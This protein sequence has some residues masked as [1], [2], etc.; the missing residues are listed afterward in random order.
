MQ[1]SP[2]DKIGPYE[3]LASI[4]AGGMGEVYRAQDARLNRDVAIKVSSAQFSERFEREAKAI[5]AL[6]HPNICQIY[7]IGPNYL[8]MEFVDGIP[9][10]S[11]ERPKALPP[12][13]ARRLATQIVAALEAAHAKGIIHRDIKPANILATTGGVVKLL[14]FGLAKQSIGTANEDVTQ[15]MGVTQAGTILGTP[16]YMSPEQAEGRTA[17]ARSDIFSFGIVLYEMLSGRRAFAGSSAAAVIGAI[18]HKEPEPLNAP[19]ELE[20]IVRRCL[21]KSPDDR[22]QTATDL[23]RALE[24]ASAQGI[25]GVKRR[26]IAFAIAVSLLVIGAAGL[27]IYLNGTKTSRIDSIA[28]LP[29]ENHDNNPDADYISDGITE[30]VN[31]SLAQVPGLKVIPHSVALHYR[32]NALDIQK[33]GDQLGVRAVLS[34]RVGQRGDNL[35]VGVEL[36][37]V[38]N[39]KQLWGEQYNGKLADLLSVQSDIAREV[40][41]RLRL[42][43]S[44]TD[45]A[46]LTRGSTNNPEAYQLYLKGKYYTNEFTKEGFSKGLDYFHQAVAID[47][48]YGLA[49]NGLAYNYINQQDWYIRPHEAGPKAK[50][51]AERAL[52]IDASDSDAYVALAIESQW[53]EW[54]WPASETA[55][56]RAI[57]L[58]PNNSE[59]HAYYSWLLAPMGRGDQ[60]LAE[61]KRA[62]QAAP[63]SP[64]AN[65]MVGSAFV[66]TR[67]W[68]LAVEQLRS[69]KELDP[70]FWFNPLF[71]GRAYEQQ[72]KFPEAIA[73]FQRA[74]ELDK[75]NTEIWSGIGHAY[76]LSGNRTKAQQVL[77]HLKELSA[78]NYVA[79]YT[80]AVIYA[81]LGDK[82]QAFA[83]LERA[84]KERSY[85]MAVY[86]VTDA[87]LDSLHSDL[88]FVDLRRRVGLPE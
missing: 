10:V 23:R 19:P 42:Q 1:L 77:D 62:V 67:Q 41:Q 35:T 32:G 31:N 43:L 50:E 36:D 68:D 9:I 20:A 6:N 87:R 78:H 49:Y 27:G 29:L 64:L 26:P 18:V 86:L 53:Y 65:F 60:A 72:G 40:S 63:F 75:D 83:W 76:A 82:H 22:F 16:S 38:G 14:D 13:E 59:A 33:I 5:A 58:N 30:S 84:Y 25:S 66:F 47:P 37:D 80:Y 12:A 54:N 24:G 88:R 85:F 48:N 52:A 28:V 81:G 57:E 3:I 8:V 55:F 17:D 39:G 44:V 79:P 61:A 21:S 71:L 74:L 46:Q 15:S 45:Q 34:G 73:E 56:K 11:R 70:T 4:G 51:A 2:G 7:D 69:A